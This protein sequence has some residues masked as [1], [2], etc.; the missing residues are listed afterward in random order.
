MTRRR[1]SSPPALRPIRKQAQTSMSISSSE[2]GE[3]QDLQPPSRPISKSS[4]QQPHEIRPPLNNH[5]NVYNNNNRAANLLPSPPPQIL[6]W[7]PT[8]DNPP[9]PPLKLHIRHQRNP[10]RR[11]SFRPRT[12]Q[13]TRRALHGAWHAAYM[14]RNSS[15]PRAQPSP[16]PHAANRQRVLQTS[17]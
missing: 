16:Y 11:R 1:W 9:L 6:Q 15:L 8:Q 10:T 2:D 7:Q 14:R 13:A 17:R 4:T 12:P 5:Q 3:I